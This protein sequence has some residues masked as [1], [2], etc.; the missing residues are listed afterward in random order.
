[1]ASAWNTLQVLIVAPVGRDARLIEDALTAAGMRAESLPTVQ[2]AT[3]RLTGDNVGALLLTEEVMDA[4][5]VALLAAELAK[6]PAWSDLPVLVLTIGGTGTV[7]SRQR[8][9]DRLPLGSVT[10]LER[11]IRMATLLS[12]VRSALRSRSR[13]YEVRDTLLERDAVLVSLQNSESRLRLA[14]ET[15]RLGSWEWDLATGAML[16]SSECCK[17]FDL[18]FGRHL[19]RNDFLSRVH[20]E[21]RPDVEQKL[22]KAVAERS[23]YTAEYR[24]VWR[25]ESVRWVSSSG[26][27]QEDGKPGDSPSGFVFSPRLVGVTLDVTDRVLSETALR[28][29]AKLA[30]VGRLASSI[31]HEINNPLE[32][33]TNLLYLLGLANLPS[34]EHGYVLAAQ[35]ELARVSEITAQTLAFNRQRNA[36]ELSVVVD[37]LDSVLA[38][39]QGRLVTSNIAVSRR[40]RTRE[41][42]VSYPG[43]LRQ[44]FSNLIGNA[45]DAMRQGGRI[46]V[47]VRCACHPRTGSPGQRITVADSGTGMPPQVQSRLFEAFH[48]TKGNNGTGLG[49]WISKGIIEKHGGSLRFSSSTGSGHRGTVFSIFLPS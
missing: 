41:P 40:Y 48:S 2:E 6:Q 4:N 20:P 42:I 31:A 47:R 8:E 11:P 34:T 44:V 19:T 14:L 16:A 35:Q 12:G 9:K 26:R 10:L 3:A 30:L 23:E 27:L 18:P 15:A 5:R 38:L 45:F 13:Q 39:Y 1:M 49:L 29:A 36:H 22:G 33:V 28:N 37:I 17:A 46:V 21:D 25:D 43:E 7:L 24:V 32:S